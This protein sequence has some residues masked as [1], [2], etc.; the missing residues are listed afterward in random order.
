MPFIEIKTA[1][2]AKAFVM[3]FMIRGGKPIRTLGSVKTLSP[4]EFGASRRNGMDGSVKPFGVGGS[5]QAVIW[6]IRGALI[7]L[8]NRLLHPELLHL[9]VSAATQHMFDIGHAL[10]MLIIKRYEHATG[11]TVILFDWQLVNE[12]W[13]HCIAN[14]DALYID[15]N[16]GELGILEIKTPQTEEGMRPFKLMARFGNRPGQLKAIPEGYRRQIQFYMA[17]LR[18]DQATICGST[19][20]GLKDIGYT[21]IRRLSPEVEAKF[22]QRSERFV[23]DTAKGILPDESDTQSDAAVIRGYEQ[24]GQL[25]PTSK[26]EKKLPAE[27]LPVIRENERLHNAIDAA[28]KELKEKQKEA[29]EELGLDELNKRLK[30]TE[31]TIAAAMATSEEGRIEVDGEVH[32]VTFRNN[33]RRGFDTERFK[34][35]HPELYKQY[36]GLNKTKTRP[37]ICRGGGEQDDN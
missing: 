11:N 5:D 36:Y 4:E 18:I 30:A 25:F 17:V 35:E 2:Q 13:P 1:E 33:E 28:E 22:M 34:L 9:T 37:V 8:A 21:T 15:K 20:W 31:A 14:V 7:E 29:K 23:A 3:K 16:T 32:T 10:E 6:G 19:G 27:L 26:K 24:M 12:D